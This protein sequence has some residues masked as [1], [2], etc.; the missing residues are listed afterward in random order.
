[1]AVDNWNGLGIYSSEDL[2]HWERQEKNLLQ[3]PGK[4]A[5]DTDMGR[6]PGVVIN[7]KRAFLFYFTHPGRT[8]DK[9]VMDNYHTRRSSLQVAELEYADGQI[10][11]DRDKP[12]Y[13]DLGND[14]A[15]E[16]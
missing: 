1:M 2:I 8:P 14:S 6:H 13:I 10:V 12:V 7:G 3:E 16:P 15:P 9:K 11:C 4:G 5:D